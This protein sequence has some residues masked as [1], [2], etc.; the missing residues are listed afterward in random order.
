[1]I[2]Q[3][4][5]QPEN[6]IRLRILR[7]CRFYLTFIAILVASAYSLQAFDSVNNLPA[8]G[9]A[10]AE[11]TGKSSDTDKTPPADNSSQPPKKT[12]SL[13]EPNLGD[14]L[15]RK[16]AIAQAGDHGGPGQAPHHRQ[17]LPFS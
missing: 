11:A 13:E 7:K 17:F 14:P 10:K 4:A 2:N 9:Q 16:G 12:F 3:A 1:M 15:A 6:N 5:F 8:N